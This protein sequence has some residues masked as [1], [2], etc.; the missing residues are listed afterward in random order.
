VV[1][2][3]QLG[4]IRNFGWLRAGRLARGEQPPLD[5]DTLGTL[6]VE[7]IRSVI[8]LRQEAERAGTLDGRFTPEY[9][10]EGQRLACERVGLR[11]HHVGCTDYQAP[12]P[13]E[14]ADGLQAIDEEV[15]AGRPVLVHCRAGVGRTSIVTSAWLM[16]DGMDGNEAAAI[17]VQFLTELDDRLKIPPAFWDA[18]LKRVGRAQSW[19]GLCQIAEALGTPITERFPLPEPE[20]PA[21]AAGWEQWYRDALQPW[22]ERLGRP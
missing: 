10:A 11:F 12:R 19:W 7:G 16:A 8:S 5:D 4:G 22:R 18:Y 2:V 14:V 21:E 13:D 1:E 17:H 15:G 3:R 9:S 6:A 20:R